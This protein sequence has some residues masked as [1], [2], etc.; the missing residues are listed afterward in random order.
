MTTRQPFVLAAAIAATLAIPSY[1]CNRGNKTTPVSE[2]QTQSPTVAV[3]Q[4][5]NVTGC[6]RAGE[7]ADTFVLTTSGTDVATYNLLAREGVNLADHVGHQ[8]EINGILATQQQTASRAETP[9]QTDKSRKATG[10]SGTPTVATE[11]SVDIRQLEVNSVRTT[12]KEC[13]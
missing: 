12:G 4:P 3:N 11:T 7:A 9:A 1:G 10:T 13:R 6:L 2:T 8:V 5:L